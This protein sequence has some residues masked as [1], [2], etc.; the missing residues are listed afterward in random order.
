M[1]PSFS[2]PR[3]ANDENPRTPVSP[4][5]LSD[6]REAS[7]DRAW[8]WTSRCGCGYSGGSTLTTSSGRRRCVSGVAGRVRRRFPVDRADATRRPRDARRARRDGRGLEARVLLQRG[9]AL[10]RVHPTP[11]PRSVCPVRRH[12]VPRVLGKPR[13]SD[14]RRRPLDNTARRGRRRAIVPPDPPLGDARSSPTAPITAAA[15]L[16]FL[17]SRRRGRLRRRPR[18]SASSIPPDVHRASSRD[19]TDASPHSRASRAETRTIRRY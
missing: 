18:T 4:P 1:L 11:G 8:R 13:L 6:A 16:R 17:P 14:R 9:V 19:T 2:R 5:D 10:R 12:G 15:F 3:R 7:C